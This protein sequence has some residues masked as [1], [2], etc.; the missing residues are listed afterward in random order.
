MTNGIIKLKANINV[1][2]RR[3]I[4]ENEEAAF[5]LSMT[6][7]WHQYHAAKL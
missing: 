1:N 5:Y 4:N 3:N 7:K 2:E 6:K